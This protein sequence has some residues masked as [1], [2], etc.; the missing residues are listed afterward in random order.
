LQQFPLLLLLPPLLLLKPSV[1]DL[2]RTTTVT[3]TISLTTTICA[4]LT[5]ALQ[6]YFSP[7]AKIPYY[8]SD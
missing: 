7:G 8:L 2:A 4:I 6:A 1:H 5:A 3:A